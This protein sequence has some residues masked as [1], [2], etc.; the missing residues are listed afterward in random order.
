MLH[1]SE[2]IFIHQCPTNLEKLELGLSV[3]YSI[4]G[5]VKFQQILLD[6]RL[7]QLIQHRHWQ[8][9]LKPEIGFPVELRHRGELHYYVVN[10][11]IDLKEKV[12][13]NQL[14]TKHIRMQNT[15]GTKM[16]EIPSL[17]CKY[18]NR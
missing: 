10:F 16:T 13:A 2:A 1:P 5:A 14:H 12:C 17:T 3:R 6:G 4:V 8:V 18:E 7:V 9:V 11:S 15:N